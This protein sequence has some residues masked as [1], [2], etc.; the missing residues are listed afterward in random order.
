[1]KLRDLKLTEG[2]VD[3]TILGTIQSVAANGLNGKL[4][5]TIIAKALMAIQNG[6]T[7]RVSNFNEY[8][9]EFAPA[10]DML[11]SLL[12][13]STENAKLLGVYALNTLQAR[14]TLVSSYGSNRS[15]GE[16]IAHATHAEARD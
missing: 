4:D 15:I 10:A 6:Y 3:P 7:F 14:N 5:A 11:D 16:I 1:M 13:L 8:F 9:N 12:A 2:Q